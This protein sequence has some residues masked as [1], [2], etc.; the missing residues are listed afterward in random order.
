MGEEWHIEGGREGREIQ[1]VLRAVT[2]LRTTQIG[3]FAVGSIGTI[4]GLYELYQLLSS[5]GLFSIVG[6][7]S[8]II[9]GA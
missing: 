9:G 2:D 7:Y 1:L 3:D 6:C 4:I 5:L 8:L